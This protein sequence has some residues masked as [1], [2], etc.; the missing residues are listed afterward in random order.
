LGINPDGGATA[1]SNGM[2]LVR[3][4]ASPL[5]FPLATAQEGQQRLSKVKALAVL[6]S[7]AL[8]SVAYATE[9]ILLALVVAGQIFLGLAL[10]V[11]IAIAGLLLIVVVS[12]R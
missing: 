7:D 6:A 3:R 10:P 9:E 5:R 12:Y 11:A 1:L 8:S 2:N 4:S